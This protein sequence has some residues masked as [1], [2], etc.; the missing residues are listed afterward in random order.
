MQA[1]ELQHAFGVG[2]KRLEFF[3]RFLRRCDFHQF[4]FV[5]LVHPDDATRLTARRAGF[6]AETRRICHELFRKIVESEDLIATQICQ[7]NFSSW[8][9]EKLAFVQAIHVSFEL[10]ELRRADHAIAPD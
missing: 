1:K 6:A 10:R 8:R 3:V 2:S 9:K 5:E 7:L 4:Y